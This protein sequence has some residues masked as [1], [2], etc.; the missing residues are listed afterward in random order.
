MIVRSAERDGTQSDT[1]DVVV[2]GGGPAGSAAA[3]RLARQGLHV[4]QLERRVFHAPTNDALRS[5]EGLLPSTIHELEQ[6][7]AGPVRSWA[8]GTVRQLLVRWRDGHSTQD[9]FPPHSTL[10]L[11][12]RER[13]DHHL[14]CAAAAAG[15]DSRQGW[16]VSDLLLDHNQ[17]CRGVVAAGPDGKSRMITAKVVID[18]GGRNARSITQLD[19]RKT[20]TDPQF[21]AV[22]LYVDALPKLRADQWEMHFWNGDGLAVMQLTQLAPGLVRCGLGINVRA[23]HCAHGERPETFFWR[24][25]AA[26]PAL[27]QRLR[28]ARQVRPFYARAEL[29]YRV[30]H[31]AL[32]GL[33]LIGDAAGYLNPILGDG[34]WAALR[35]AAIASDVAARACR[36]NDVSQSRL[37]EYEQ[38]W[39]AQRR[40]RWFIGRAL[41]QSSEYPQLLAAAAYIPPIRRL[42]LRR[43][44]RP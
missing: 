33:L 38:C 35:S 25:V 15:V 39:S 7:D 40:M 42:L 22:V 3:L 37:Q 13:F 23:K 20:T 5:G 11:V 27:E 14:F 9:R 29:G 44:L 12:H 32:P 41:L 30:S 10:T 8:L 24:H 26:Y 36:A 6:L 19:L 4:I 28:S 16:K 21:I 18:A 2:V 31:M 34:I 43:L 17:Q 1:C